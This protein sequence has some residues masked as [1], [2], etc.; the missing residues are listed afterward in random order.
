MQSIYLKI[1][2]YQA[3]TC[4]DELGQCTSQANTNRCMSSIL[5]SVSTQLICQKTCNACNAYRRKTQS[6]LLTIIFF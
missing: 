6:K 1:L 5:Q 3:L 4:T 2:E